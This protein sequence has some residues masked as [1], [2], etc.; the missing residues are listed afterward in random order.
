[1]LLADGLSTRALGRLRLAVTELEA[2][3]T[4]SGSEHGLQGVY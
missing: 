4:R 3:F 1:M 2:N